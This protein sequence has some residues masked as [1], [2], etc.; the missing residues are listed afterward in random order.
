MAYREVNVFDVK[1]VL[2]RWLRGDAKKAIAR[3][4]G[5]DPKTVR[6]YVAAAEKVGLRAPADEAALAEETLSAVMA[7]VQ[8]RGGRP[9]GPGWDTCERE[10]EFIAGLLKDGVLLTKIRKLLLRQRRAKVSYGTLRRYAM[11]RLGFAEPER[12]IPVADGQPGEELQVDTGWMTYL[13]RD[14]SGRRRRFRAWIFTPVVSRYRF[15]YPVFPESTETAIEACEA[16]WAFYGGV[17]RVLVPDNT[18]AIVV[19]PDALT[20]GVTRAFQEYAQ[21]RGLFVDP[22]RVK[23]P[24]DKARVENAVPT[25]RKDCFGG[26]KL[27]DLEQARAHA[28]W[29]CDEDYGAREHRTTRRSPREHFLVEE[30]SALLPAPNEAYDVP[31]WCEPRVDSRQLAPVLGAMYSVP[32]RF[33]G[34]K[35]MAR[36]DRSLVRFYENLVVVKVHPRQPKGGRSIDPS[37]YPAEK[38]IYAFRNR[39]ALLDRAKAHGDQ[40]GRF[41]AALLAGPEPWA[42][43]RRAYALLRLVK[44]YGA[45]RVEQACATANAAQMIDVR[46]LEQMLAQAA[47]TP[48]APTDRV[49]PI[50]RYLRPAAHFGVNKAKGGAR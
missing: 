21:A 11:E 4:V 22:A 42:R 45:A 24:K 29:W 40:V 49:V 3:Q 48:V 47:A 46:R 43:M 34:K 30:K 27:L 9:R 38:A 36:A 16:A 13:S 44:R 37:D 5:V 19:N 12:S 7:E 8:P 15:V 20:P 2:R 14:G 1:E 17:F 31:H 26:E 50:A 23:K 32:E 41:A 6:R 18:K 10:R 39:E 35:I 33:A 28:L 25:V